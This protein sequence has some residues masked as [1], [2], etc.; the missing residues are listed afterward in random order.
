MLPPTNATHFKMSPLVFWQRYQIAV[1]DDGVWRLPNKG[2]PV[3]IAWSDVATVRADDTM[4]RL[5]VADRTHDRTIKI[6]YQLNDFSTLRDYILQHTTLESRASPTGKLT[7]YRTRINKIVL[8]AS[9]IPNFAV[10]ILILLGANSTIGLLYLTLPMSLVFL[11]TR[12]PLSLAITPNR[13]VIHYPGWERSI[14]F[15]EISS[16]TLSDDSSRGNVW[17][18]VVITLRRGKAIKLYRFREGYLALL[19]ALQN[20]LKSYGDSALNSRLDGGAPISALSP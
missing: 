19:E 3:F 14:S 15:S 12:D 13:V 8:L 10:G 5:V 20:A 9:S 2:Q 17:F 7:F 18:A 1:D 11:V 16:V 4:Q 6:D